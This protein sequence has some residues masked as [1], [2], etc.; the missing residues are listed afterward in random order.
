MCSMQQ[1]EKVNTP[2]YKSVKHQTHGGCV[3][4]LDGEYKDMIY[5][6][7]IVSLAGDKESLN[8]TYS[9]IEN[10]NHLAENDQ[11]KYLMGSILVDIIEK[12]S[13]EIDDARK[14]YR[15]SNT[16]KSDKK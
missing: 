10:P 8:F 6:Y 2:K 5:S 14:K 4:V 3:L 9:I 11:M 15:I 16:N 12:N 7:G 13:E 1:K